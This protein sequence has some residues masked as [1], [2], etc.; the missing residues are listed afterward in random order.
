M[1]WSKQVF[2]SHSEDHYKGGECYQKIAAGWI[3]QPVPGS[4][5]YAILEAET[6]VY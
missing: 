5:L 1:C 4:Y 3:F 2:I 6:L